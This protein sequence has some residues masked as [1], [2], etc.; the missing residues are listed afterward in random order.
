MSATAV[1]SYESSMFELKT[2]NTQI[3]PLRVTATEDG[4]P[5]TRVC[6]QHPAIT[7]VAPPE[8]GPE[9]SYRSSSAV[10]PATPRV[11]F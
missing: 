10:C 9:L 2:R 1:T 8:P 11:A 4:N 3:E 5:A 6:G 7:R